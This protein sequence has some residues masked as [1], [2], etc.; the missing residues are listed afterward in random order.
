M[1]HVNLY[2]PVWC[3]IE[4]PNWNTSTMQ[5]RC[6]SSQTNIGKTPCIEQ[7]AK[8]DG[9]SPAFTPSCLLAKDLLSEE[10]VQLMRKEDEPYREIRSLREKRRK[11]W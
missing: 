1:Y 3:T 7:R 6:K 2:D 5:L 10:F 4:D 8:H 9:I 11:G